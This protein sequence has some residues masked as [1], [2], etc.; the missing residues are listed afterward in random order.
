MT[1]KKNVKNDSEKQIIEKND[2]V[3]ISYK[4]IDAK[5]NI[6]DESHESQPLHLQYGKTIINKE[7]EKKLKGK[8][9]GDEII[10]K[11]EFKTKSPIIE[12]TLDDLDE[13][14]FHSYEKG[15][16]I[17]L[18]QNDKPAFFIVERF[19][20]QDGKLFVRYKPP[21]EGSTLTNKIKIEKIIKR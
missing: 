9:V 14:E 15:E 16:I 8:S 2:L 13:D 21:Y 20:L 1:I 11:Q 3:T 18:T 10:I 6:V 7:L 17:E 4:L 5:G 12:L 19:N